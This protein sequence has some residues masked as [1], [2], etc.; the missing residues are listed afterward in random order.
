VDPDD[1]D[2]LLAFLF[3]IYISFLMAMITGYVFIE[4]LDTLPFIGSGLAMSKGLTD[5][6]SLGIGGMPKMAPPGSDFMKNVK[7]KMLSSGT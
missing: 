1:K 5:E 4:L 7:D 3:K 6:K 2:A